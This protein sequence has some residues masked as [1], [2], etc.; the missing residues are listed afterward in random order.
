M[1]R[2]LYFQR[3]LGFLSGRSFCT[4]GNSL[5]QPRAL[6]SRRLLKISSLHRLILAYIFDRLPAINPHPLY[7][8][9]R[10]HY[11]STTYHLRLK[12]LLTDGPAAEV[13]IK[14][15]E[16]AE[17]ISEGTLKQWSKS[18]GDHVEQD[19]E[20]A[21][22]ETDKIDVSVNAP[23]AGTLKEFL[24][25]EEDTVTVGQDLAKLD[26]GVASD[27]GKREPAKTEAKEPASR[28]QSTPS[29]PNG[30]ETTQNKQP[31][32]KEDSTRQ[33]APPPAVP[34]SPEPKSDKATQHDK[35]KVENQ[36]SSSSSTGS[37]EERRV[38]QLSNHIC[39]VANTVRR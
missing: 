37:R 12:V 27:G 33:Q 15:P 1:L 20:I 25:K 21:T 10:R 4:A 30:E 32:Q 31:P 16:M 9:Q 22:I 18:V 29:Q 13:M 39:V 23:Q 5:Q 6:S 26:A 2:P 24:A 34:K 19:E 14:V 11:G 38:S 7:C 3:G 8:G 35:S 17:S 28:Q 36:V